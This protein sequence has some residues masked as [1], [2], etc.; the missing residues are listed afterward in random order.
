MIGYSGIQPDG[1]GPLRTWLRRPIVQALLVAVFLLA[2]LLPYWYLAAIWCQDILPTYDEQFAFVTTTFLLVMVIAD[3]AFLTRYYQ[4]KRKLELACMTEELRISE[5]A[6]RITVKKLS[7]LSSITRH[8]IRN[9]LL[10]LKIYLELIRTS[11]GDTVQMAEYF[12][13]VEQMAA[14]IERQLDFTLTYESL[15]AA[16]PE[17]QDLAACIGKAQA[18]LDL[19]GTR[20]TL[21]GIPHVEIFADPLLQNVFSNLFDN[22]L[23]HGGQGM[24]AI[25]IT[26]AE[27]EGGLRITFEDNGIGVPEEEKERIFERGFG[28]NTGFGLFLIREI[29]DI[30]RIAIRETGTPGTGARFEITVPAGAYR[31]LPAE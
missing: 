8:D 14:S 27:T 30:T 18:G 21:A 20:V 25:T 10:G 9:K 23:R 2:V 31:I 4:A 15:G 22:S 16:H 12:T 24:N 28:E 26:T 3:S 19:S 17:F 6:L 5:E 7:L 11:S 13:R 29:L 1:F